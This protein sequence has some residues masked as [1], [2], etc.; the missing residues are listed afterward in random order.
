MISGES[1]IPLG[2]MV[3]VVSDIFQSITYLNLNAVCVNIVKPLYKYN[4]VH[5]LLIKQR[6]QL[7]MLAKTKCIHNVL[8]V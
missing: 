1:W 3:S 4:A 8:S 6:I 2:E 7:M 5:W